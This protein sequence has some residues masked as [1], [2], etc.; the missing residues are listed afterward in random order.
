MAIDIYDDTYIE[1]ES[2]SPLTL[3]IGKILGFTIAYC[4]NDTG[5]RNAFIG[6]KSTHG[7]NNDEGYTNADVFG[8]LELMNIDRFD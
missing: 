3:S 2:N 6:S 1:S 8:T 4:D 5:S 7:S